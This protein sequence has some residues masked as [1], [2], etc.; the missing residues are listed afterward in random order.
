MALV[1]IPAIGSASNKP[2]QLKVRISG[3]RAADENK[4][5]V[6]LGMRKFFQQREF[7]DAVLICEDQ[8]FHVHKCVLAAKSEVFH[9]LLKDTNEIRFSDINN[10]EAVRWMLDYFYEIGYGKGSDEAVS[11]GLYTPASQAINADVLRLAQK[12][13]LPALRARATLFMT[14]ELSTHNAVERLAICDE[15]GLTELRERILEQL[16]A[17]KKA[18]AE[19]T[20]SPAI[21]AYPTLM[22]EMLALIATS[23]GGLDE[24]GSNGP[25]KKKM[26]R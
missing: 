2:V 22:R 11:G 14:K 24:L 26:K 4:G 8:E 25:A 18:L 20:S 9:N 15:F 6:L 21:T 1:S 7:C 17:N 23:G 12:Y 3:Y 13:E 10:P 5:E 16:T 19:V